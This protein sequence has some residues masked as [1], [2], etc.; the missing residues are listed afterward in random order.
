MIRLG[1]SYITAYTVTGASVLQEDLLLIRTDT[2]G[3]TV[4]AKRYN[5][6]IGSSLHFLQMA[7]A[8]NNSF[9]VS[10][11]MQ[12]RRCLFRVDKN[13]NLVWA[14]KYNGSDPLFFNGLSILPDSG[15]AVATQTPAGDPV[16]L[17]V[18]KDG[19]V[20]AAL[21]INQVAFSRMN[22]FTFFNNSLDVAL[23]NRYV[24]NISDAGAINW[25]RVYNTSNQFNALVSNRCKNGD[26]IYL[27]G[28]TS[29][30]ISSGTVRVFRTGSNGVL[31][32][33]KN[34]AAYHKSNKDPLSLFDAVEQGLVYENTDG[35]IIALTSEESTS[36]MMIVFD[37]NGNYL[38]NRFLNYSF[39]FLSALP[40]GRMLHA[41]PGTLFS[42]PVLGKRNF[43][44]KLSCDSSLFVDI[45]NGTDSAATLPLLTVSPFQA[46]ANDMTVSISAVAINA[47]PFCN[48]LHIADKAGSKNEMLVY[49]NPAGD[50]VQVKSTGN[51]PFNIY[52]RYGNIQAAGITNRPCNISSLPGGIYMVAVKTDERV[53]SLNFLKN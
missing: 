41:S 5:A 27:A 4:W 39:N 23:D 45:T 25:Q 13:G 47:S 12:F 34:V 48:T 8:D 20:K 49:P 31:K 29:G 18:H 10:G 21:R 28:R 17:R 24:L 53:I 43:A 46:V 38:Y 16:I 52:D 36:N 44:V 15:I 2:N 11:S 3:N 33:C 40:D 51:F 42:E 26:I 9:I 32:W 19:T 7:A 14:K 22:S 35:N 50:F 30:G 37:K 6:G 1:S